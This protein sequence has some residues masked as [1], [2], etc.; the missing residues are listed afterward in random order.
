MLEVP[1]VKWANAGSARSEVATAGTAM[2]EV[3][4]CWECQE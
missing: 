1:G 4:Q 2:S 3:G